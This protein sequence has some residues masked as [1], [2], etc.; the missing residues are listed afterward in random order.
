MTDPYKTLGLAQTATLPEI[1]AAYRKLARKYHPDL[2]PGNKGFEEKFKQVSHSFDLIGTT[3]AKAKYDRGETDEQKQQMYEE[4][5]RNQGKSRQGP[6]YHQ[7]QNDKSRY[8]SAFGEGMDDDIFSQF[9]SGGAGAPKTKDERYQ[10][11]V[12]FKEAALGTEKVITLP[13]GKKMQVKIPAGIEQGQKLKFKGMGTSGDV[14]IEIGIKPS[15]QFK[16]N[17]KDI[18]SDVA[19][20]FFEA[21]NGCEIEVQTIDGPVMLKVPPGVSTGSKLRIKNK[22]AGIGEARGNHIVSL[23]TVMPKDPSPELLT[24][25]QDL[26][27]RFSYNPRV[28]S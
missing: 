12:D 5:V 28:S 2:N 14:Y 18:L 15:L 20:S 7:T 13:S 21:F 8:S 22:G 23:K 19:L 16:R 11:E 26:G 9:F 4:H 27:N 6:Y 10:L 24:A 1:K 25:I 3:E 17:G